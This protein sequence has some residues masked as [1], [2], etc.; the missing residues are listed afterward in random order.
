[1][2]ELV[3]QLFEEPTFDT[4]RTKETLGYIANFAKFIQREITGGIIYVQSN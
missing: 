4:L 2:F 1:L 3:T